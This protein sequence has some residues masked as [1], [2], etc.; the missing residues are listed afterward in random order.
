VQLDALSALELSAL[1][2]AAE[3][4]DPPAFGPTSPDLEPIEADWRTWLTTIVP[5]Y[6][7][8]PFA[9]HH[10]EFWEWV[11]GLRPGVRPRPF[12]GIWPRG[13][14]KSTSAETA[15]VTL[16]ARGARR[17]ALYVCETQDQADDHVANVAAIL[18]LRSI[19]EF[20]PELGTPLLG[21]HGNS[22]GWRRNRLRTAAGFTIDAL[23]LDSAARGVK[24]E[25]QRP[26]LMVIDDIDGEHD[27]PAAVK[28]KIK[29]LTKKIFPAGSHDLAVL[30]IQNLVHGESVF[31]MLAGLAREKADFLTDRIV[32][33]PVPAVEGLVT[34]PKPE[35]GYRIVAG[36][37]TWPGQ[38]LETCEQQIATWGLSAF[39]T[40]AQ[41]DI[42]PASGGMW[43]HI[44]FQHCHRHDVPPL[45]RVVVWVDPAVTLTDNSDSHAIQA[46]GLGVDGRVYRLHSWEQRATPVGS[47]VRAL[48]LAYELGAEKVGV[49]T[50]QGGD[51]WQSVY[52]EALAKVLNEHPDWVG[53]PIPVF[54]QDK[55][56]AGHGPKVHRSQQM[57]VDY[58]TAYAPVHVIGTHDVLEAA[59]RRFP[60]TKPFDLADAAY[61]SWQDLVEETTD[62]WT[63][64]PRQSISPI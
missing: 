49:E 13:G 25:D 57:L 10:E 4:L 19:S 58:E 3:R 56:G 1:S 50:D 52:R 28:K 9:K 11:W 39:L 40:E 6:C 12:T 22:K 18:E 62:G 48:E 51:T 21:K 45:V 31:S 14:A 34:E 42:T 64:E 8:A 41:H 27:E 32:S 53:L 2:E 37:A 30:A 20:Y 46:D 59:L 15:C 17:Y 43:D 44:E 7:S 5:D 47:L 55:A 54:D 29:T 36:E 26:D 35:G 24:L 38:S 23:G 60:K 16:A 63:E 61:W 33:G